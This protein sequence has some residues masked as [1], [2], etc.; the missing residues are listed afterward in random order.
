PIAAALYR[1]SS[2]QDA[3]E[4]HR[5]AIEEAAEQAIRKGQVIG[6]EQG[7]RSIEPDAPSRPDDSVRPELAEK[8]RRSIEATREA[9]DQ[10]ARELTTIRDQWT[11]RDTVLTL[12]GLVLTLASD[13]LP[14]L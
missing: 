10:T 1:I 9:L 2:D 7:A 3:L 12:A 8:L 4:R 6:G 5:L 14:L 13:A 11:R